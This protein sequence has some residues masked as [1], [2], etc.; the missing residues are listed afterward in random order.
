MKTSLRRLVPMFLF[1]AGLAAAV[2]A[3]AQSAKLSWPNLDA[4]AQK[5]EDSVDVT[6]DRALLQLAAGFLGDDA[7]AAEV[8]AL[9]RDIESINVRHFE[10][11]SAGLYD[12]SVLDPVRAQLG[13]GPWQRLIAAREG[14]A[15]TEV[16]AWRDAGGGPGGLAVVSTQPNELTLVNIVGKI[17]VSRLRQ[18]EGHLGIPKVT[19]ADAP[20]PKPE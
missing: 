16:Y 14:G 18:L 12:P 15:N 20:R 3:D 2:P 13:K 10:F 5:A 19:P 7:D 11:N 1:A 9:L 17:D 4:I 6:L 8:K